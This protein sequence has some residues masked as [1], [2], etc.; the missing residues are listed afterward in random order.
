MATLPISGLLAEFEVLTFESLDFGAEVSDFLAQSR[1]RGNHLPGGVAGPTDLYQLVIHDQPG[2]PKR[3][4][5]GRGQ[6][7]QFESKRTGKHSFGGA[8][9]RDRRR[10]PIGNHHSRAPL[11]WPSIT[12]TAVLSSSAMSRNRARPGFR[13]WCIPAPGLESTSSGLPV[14]R[15]APPS[16]AA[17]ER[18]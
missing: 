10:A 8:L 13:D 3:D 9:H 17:A 1:H 5:R 14:L 12:S 7:S 6:S 18:G 11:R 16:P 15:S 4:R 2:L